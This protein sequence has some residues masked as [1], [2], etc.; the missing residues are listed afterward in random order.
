M[1]QANLKQIA[2]HAVV[3][4]DLFDDALPKLLPELEHRVDL[5]YIDGQHD[6]EAT[7][8]YFERLAPFLKDGAL[9]IFDD[10]H[11]SAGMWQAWLDLQ[12]RARLSYTIDAGRVGICGWDSA[13]A[14][15][16]NYSISLFTGWRT[17]SPNQ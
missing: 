7:L 3:I 5:V 2:D 17:R 8:D 1:A 12:K 14:A 11:W 15:P 13:S 6:Y 9:L 4:N 16:K 10:I